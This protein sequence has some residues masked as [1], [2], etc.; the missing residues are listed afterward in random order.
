MKKVGITGGTGFIGRHL[1]A[2]LIRNGY[3]VVVFTT[4]VAKRRQKQHIS[5]AHWNPENGACDLAAI[6]SVDIMVNLA[7]E[8]I[9]DRR[10]NAKR[11]KEIKNSRVKSTSFLVA[12]LNAYAPNCKALIT[13]S[14]TGYYGA[15]NHY[16]DS[17]TETAPAAT[18]F[19]AETC[20]Q[21]EEAS[22]K[23]N[24]N[25]RRV[26]LRFGIVLGKGSGAFPQLSGPMVYGFAP[27][28]GSGGQV[29]SWIEIHDLVRLILFAIEHPEVAG[30]YNAVAPGHVSH[31]EL[32][33]TIA[34][35]KKGTRIPIHVPSAL[36]KIL[37]GEMSTEVL[38]SCT[39]SADKIVAA[40]FVFD[41]PD[42][43]SAVNAILR[44]GV[45]GK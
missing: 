16:S 2:L 29:V 40:G 9:A 8:G 44:P 20:R 17:Y 31:R 10:W 1:T 30:I 18:D 23:L 24:N 36:L 28:L 19:L 21:W 27:I 26:V 12:H 11:K 45:P 6:K 14:A 42:I 35:M 13:A 34:S 43:V 3:E 39:V 37:L 25:I 32:M 38:K 22:E 41:H 15:D 5:Y 7:G 4:G 33:H